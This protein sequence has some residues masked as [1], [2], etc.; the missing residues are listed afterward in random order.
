M[1][2]LTKQGKRIIIYNI[3][4]FSRMFFPY[5]EDLNIFKDIYINVES[6]ASRW[7]Y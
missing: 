2:I 1:H 4:D 5:K 3:P 6:M 7:I